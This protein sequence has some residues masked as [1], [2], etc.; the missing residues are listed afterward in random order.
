MITNGDLSLASSFPFEVRGLV[1]V[2]VNVVTDAGNGVGSSQAFRTSVH[3]ESFRLK[4]LFED[5]NALHDLNSLQVV[6]MK[7]L[8]FAL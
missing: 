3:S 2:A 5:S 1:H 4:G 6:G 7:V 8:D